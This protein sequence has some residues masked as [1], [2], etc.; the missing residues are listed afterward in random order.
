LS[1]CSF[2]IFGKRRG[3][4]AIFPVN[5][6]YGCFN[7]ELNYFLKNIFTIPSVVLGVVFLASVPV[8]STTHHPYH[9]L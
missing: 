9:P 8:L 5:A 4:N 7:A 2:E 6:I 1:E 3:N